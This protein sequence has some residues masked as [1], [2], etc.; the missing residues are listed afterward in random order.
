M[1]PFQIS[2]RAVT[3]RNVSPDTAPVPRAVSTRSNTRAS[4]KSPSFARLR[5][6]KSRWV[7]ASTSDCA[8]SSRRRARSKFPALNSSMPSRAAARAPARSWSLWAQLVRAGSQTAR[9]PNATIRDRTFPKITGGCYARDESCPLACRSSCGSVRPDEAVLPWGGGGFG[10]SAA[11]LL[12]QR[13]CPVAFHW[14]KIHSTPSGD[15]CRLSRT[16]GIPSPGI[17]CKQEPRSPDGHRS[18]TSER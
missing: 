7:G 4:T 17:A 10:L 8:R 5:A 13:V 18:L 2:N 3:A 15:R 9:M 16:K 11:S 14:S 1:G 12:V 6:M